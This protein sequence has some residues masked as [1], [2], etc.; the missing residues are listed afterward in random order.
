[1]S[2]EL[3][4]RPRLEIRSVGGEEGGDMTQP[5]VGQVWA[6]GDAYEPYV[7]RWSRLVAEEFLGWL[8]VVPQCRWLDVGCGTGALA[9]T[10]LRFTDPIRV[11]GIDPS[12]SYI[13][14]ATVHVADKRAQFRV[15]R[16]DALPFETE[17]FD[18]V[19]TGLVLNFVPSAPDAVA[20]MVRVTRRGGLIA[21]YVWD[22]A[23]DMQLI[24]RF[25]DAAIAL[26]PTAAN[27]DEGR[28]FTLCQ[29]QA[30]TKLFASADLA[31]VEARAIDIPTRFRDFT[32]YWSPFL[33]GQ[34]PAPSY[35]MS[36]TEERRTALRDQLRTTLPVDPDG[37]IHLMARAWAVRGTR[38]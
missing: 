4:F 37:S 25:W 26:D 34:A 13:A 21:A 22:Y 16:A 35:A 27:L 32:D 11:E 15:G 3:Y 10:I 5:G 12:D 28:R 38:R 24:R 30:L 8:A 2:R 23:G 33:G 9:S 31:D 19:V 18:A 17:A 36:L 1:M 14:H 7:G 6:S 29:P 20:E